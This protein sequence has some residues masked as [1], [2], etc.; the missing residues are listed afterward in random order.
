[1]SCDRLRWYR[2]GG[3]VVFFAVAAFI[4]TYPVG[5]RLG[6]QLAGVPGEDALQH[7]W[8]S[9][10]T[11]FSL[12][13]LGVNPA[14]VDWLY[15]PDG[16]YHPMLWVTPYPAVAGLPLTLLSGPVLAYNVHFLL[17]FVLSGVTTYLLV[18]YLTRNRSAALLG[19]F[20]FAF[21]P[22]R[23]AQSTAHFAQTVTYLFPLCALYLVRLRRDPNR[24][25]ALVF[26]VLL[27]VS[28]LVNIV[29]IAYLVLPLLVVFIGYGAVAERDRFW[30]VRHLRSLGLSLAT[31]AVISAPFLVPFVWQALGGRLDY[32]Q[33]GGVSDFSADLLAFFVPAAS[34]PLLGG[35]P[36]FRDFAQRLIAAGTW[37]ENT[38]YLGIVPLLLAA[39]GLVC[40][41]NERAAGG[42]ER[43]RKETKASEAD[44]QRG[45][46]TVPW[47]LLS[48]VTMVLSLGPTLKVA[49]LLTGVPLPY[50]LAQH[51][52]FYRWGRIPGRFNET[53]VLGLAVLA[54]YGLVALSRRFKRGALGLT[55]LFLVAVGL[56]YLT[57]WPFPTMAADIPDFY[58][59]WRAERA[60]DSAVLDLPQWP[61][62]LREASNRAMFYQTVHERK[63]V[64]GYVWRL[65]DYRAGTMKAFQELLW[66]DGWTDII[67]RRRGADAIPLLNQ[68]RVGYVTVHRQVLPA[69]DVANDLAMI[70][71]ALGP[72]FYDG[73]AVVAFAVPDAPPPDDVEPLTSFSYNWYLVEPVGG[74]PGRWLRNDGI[75]HV[76]WLEEPEAGYRLTFSVSSFHRRRHL[77]VSLNGRPLQEI[78]VDDRRSVE[79]G[80]LTFRRGQN[81]ITF[82][83]VEGCDVPEEIVVGNMDRRCL[84]LL[85]QEMDLSPLVGAGS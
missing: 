46:G 10:W 40:R 20:M 58:R 19:G 4:F 37:R 43:P 81:D 26:G 11:T 84:S 31:A 52:P 9:W 30:D 76:H 67:A 82:H 18:L 47:L 16:V 80:P 66:P 21:F 45:E 39:Y 7:L 62:W 79:V 33:Q 32:L 51:L 57:V 24:H 2:R 75:L 14:Q 12:I 48:L 17:T 34:H 63:I 23:M 56:D 60:E 71:E 15:Y 8:I 35:W 5:L 50:A 69:E 28:L 1:M 64:G 72:P 13:E 42:R 83:V 44:W 65:P 74:L 73:P 3:A 49:G 29:H 85:F 22:N 77:Q 59:H 54:A 61:L 41:R 55:V 53:V 38:V 27:G 78:E 6:S 70:E 25:N 36:V 68:Y